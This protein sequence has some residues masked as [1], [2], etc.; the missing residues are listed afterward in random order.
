MAPGENEFDNLALKDQRSLRDQKVRGL[1]C[2]PTVELH[3]CE[4]SQSLNGN[5]PKELW[6]E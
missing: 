6:L 4:A 3:L 5:F 1:H 2:R